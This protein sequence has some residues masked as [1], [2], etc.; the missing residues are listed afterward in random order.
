MMPARM[1]NTL[2]K[3][4]LMIGLVALV[5]G[6][7]IVYAAVTE[8]SRPVPGGMTVNVVPIER[9]VDV[10]DDL[11]VDPLDLMAIARKMG[12]RPASPVRED[13][14]HDG[15]IDVL[16]LAIVA[17]YLG[18]VTFAPPPQPIDQNPGTMIGATVGEPE[19]LDPAWQYDTDSESVIINVYEPL[20]FYRRDK[21]D[22][23]VPVLSTG[24]V[25]SQDGLT[26]IFDIREGVRFHEGGTLE[27]HDVAYSFWRGLLQ[28]RAGGPQFILLEP[29]FDEFG[30]E[31]LA[32][33]IAG[34][35]AFEDVDAAS[36]V[37]TC[38][39]VKRAV[40]FDDSAG[41]VTF[42]L[43]KPFG[44]F[45]QIL[46]SRW[47]SIL[48]QEWMVQLGDW[49]GD[50]ATWTGWHNPTAEE[51]AIFKKMN[52]TG[53]F[54][55]E[56]WVPA[57]EWSLLRNDDYWLTEPLWVGGP[58]GPAVLRRVAVK[59]VDEWGTRLSMFK[60][61]DAD[62]IFVPQQ[63]LAQMDVLVKERFEGGERDPAKLTI[64][65]EHGIARVFTHLPSPLADDGFFVFNVD[66]KGGN[67]FVGSGALD[68]DGIP[69]DFFSDI[70]VRKGFS[71]AYDRGTLIEDVY[72]GEALTRT[73][74]IAAGHI[75]HR[76]DQPVYEYDLGKAEEELRLAFDGQL[77]D[78]GFFLGIGYNSGNDKNK[79]AAEVLKHGVESINPKFKVSIFDF[80]FSTYL[81]QLFGL[82]LPLFFIGWA[83]DYHH[84]HAWVTP[85][86]H[87][88][89]TLAGL[90]TFPPELQ[91]EFDALVEE[92]VGLAGVDATPC[93]SRLQQKAHDNAIAL[94]GV[95]PSQRHY[96]QLWVEGW[97]LN[98]AYPVP[99]MW[100]YALSK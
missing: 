4:G 25:T 44:P 77:W 79:V 86:M 48:D 52:G 23:F 64:D 13:I 49:D 5:A 6:A 72:L 39:T 100:Y 62:W 42:N 40:T 68:G 12:S 47:A 22:E 93:Y 37:E 55:L 98:P 61:G 56:R 18:E 59:N 83:Q 14:N 57:E 75:G 32:T 38:E 29:L 89:G 28:D 41:R 99:Y 35:D 97:Y 45:L 63:F 53:P 78:T 9:S 43:A 85:Y 58:S 81:D 20:I 31:D 7:A 96:Q 46:A 36:L 10:N 30:V 19:S 26:Y 50:C 82:R 71:H 66:V 67:P 15:R 87:S 74:P 76:A 70:H 34:V 80:P 91:E 69:P 2:T 94:F 73:G 1:K 33:G 60:N 27:P 92:C 24:W 11:L 88:T 90:A 51:S 84:A 54:K 95:Q 17:R 21:L 65:N 16:D 3:T 8:I